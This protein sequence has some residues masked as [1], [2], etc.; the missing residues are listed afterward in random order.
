MHERNEKDRAAARS[1]LVRLVA[2]ELNSAE[3]RRRARNAP[4]RRTQSGQ[5]G[6]PA[7]LGR[8]GSA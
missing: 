5:T 8:P 1:E 6:M 3:R 4:R 2:N 7:V